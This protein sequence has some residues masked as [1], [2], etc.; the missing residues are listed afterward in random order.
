MSGL[1]GGDIASAIGAAFATIF[2]PAVLT[3][4]EPTVTS[5]PADAWNPAPRTPVDHPCTALD[6]AWETSLVAAGLVGAQD[7]K[8]LILATTIDVE[9]RA[10][11]R[12]TVRGRTYTVMPASASM[13]AVKIDPARAC[14][15]LRCSA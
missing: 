13:P 8:V 15:V 7:V 1:L 4:L 12:V 5:P 14:W 6:T 9:P 2:F 11:D 10:S 3:R